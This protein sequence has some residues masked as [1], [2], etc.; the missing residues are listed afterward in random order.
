M[1]DTDDYASPDD[2][3]DSTDNANQPDVRQK[4]QPDEQLRRA[5]EVLKNKEQKA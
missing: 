3:D 5:V 4:D 1:A 2:G